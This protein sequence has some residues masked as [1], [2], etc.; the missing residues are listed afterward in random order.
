MEE[1]TDIQQI[2][3]DDWLNDN[4]GK[5][6]VEI[7][8]RYGTDLIKRKTYEM[9][10]V[11]KRKDN[12]V[13]DWLSGVCYV[14][15]HP[16]TTKMPEIV[17]LCGSTSFIRDFDRKM[18]EFT[19]Q[20]KIVLS[21][22]THYH[23]DHGSKWEDKKPMLDDLHKHKIDLADEVYVINK[24]GYIGESTMSEVE[25]ALEIGKLVT[26]MEPNCKECGHSHHFDFHCHD[27][28]DGVKCGCTHFHEKP[29]ID[30]PL[31]MTGNIGKM[32][33]ERKGHDRYLNTATLEFES[34]GLYAHHFREK[35][36]DHYM[37]KDIDAQVSMTED[38]SI[39]IEAIKR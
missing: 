26:L 8:T 34:D 6:M 10:Y 33:A 38:G 16:H 29:S 21:V 12:E 5:E 19:L 28:D 36:I 27:F 35:V 13:K 37:E 24:D 1:L 4:I 39:R 3:L 30:P 23:S 15:L 17:V 11:H 14:M 7:I 20:G 31:I 22:G 18:L 25:Y 32:I 9:I 2:N